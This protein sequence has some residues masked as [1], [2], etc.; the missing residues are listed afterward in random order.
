LR[1][2]AAGWRRLP[3]PVD[4]IEGASTLNESL[5]PVMAVL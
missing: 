1:C 2:A 5:A 3:C 4:E